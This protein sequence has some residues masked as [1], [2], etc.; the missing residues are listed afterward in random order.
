MV[1][2]AAGPVHAGEVERALLAACARPVLDAAGQARVNQLAGAA[3]DWPLLLGLATRHG[4]V[5][6]LHRHLR[7]A[8]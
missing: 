7:G 8:S 1:A 5:A 2:V 3:P 6:F 4:L